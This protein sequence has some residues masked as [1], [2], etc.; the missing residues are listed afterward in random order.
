MNREIIVQKLQDYKEDIKKDLAQ[1]VEINSERDLT[2]KRSNAPFGIGIRKCFDKMIEFAEREGFEVKDFDGYAIH[3]DYGDGPETLAILGHVDTV[4]IYNIEKWHSDPFSLL[5]HNGFWYG[6]GVNDNK[7]PI[8]G[9]LY[10]LKILKELNVKPSKR[11]RLIIGG[12]EETTWECMEH[13]FKYNEMP[14]YGFSPD[15]DFPIVNCEKGISYYKYCGKRA[16]TNDGIININTIKSNKDIIRV[17]S[18]AEIY[19]TTKSPEK[20]VK[21]LPINENRKAYI[22]KNRLQ[23]I[24]EGVSAVGR[25]P[26]KGQNALFTFVKEFEGISGLDSRSRDLIEFLSF[27]FVDSIYGE[28]LG[29]HHE[30]KETGGTTS[31]LSY[32]ILDDRGYTVSFDYRYP[33]GVDY[34]KIVK[35]LQ[36]IANEKKLVL[37]TIKEMPLLYVSP[38]SELVRALKKA[39]KSIIGEE[40]RLFSKGAASYARA[41]KQGVAFG[42]TFS[43]DKANSHKANECLN[44]ENFMKALLIYAEAIKLLS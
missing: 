15:G 14:I 23:I 40:T 39:Y 34:G 38:E 26:H 19:I 6:R 7:G 3:I 17:C 31:N 44:I 30:D 4:G 43:T 18:R 5:E 42:P 9:C 37:V 11:I 8:L 32:V 10:L 33:N 35:K 24:Y 25:N 36:C 20:L 41:L 13:Y 21:L 12:A 16:P 1:L 2:T 29:I 27:Y 22:E 28:K